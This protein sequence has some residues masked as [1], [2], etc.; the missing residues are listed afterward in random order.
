VR[1]DP[2]RMVITQGFTQALDLLCRVLADRGATTVAIE[3]PS[4]PELWSTVR[5]SGLRLLGCP[6]DADGLRTDALRDLV[7]DAVVVGPAHQYPT[8]VVMTAARRVELVRWAAMRGR[9]VI[10]DDYDAE[11]RYDRKPIG[12]IQGLD[13]SRVAHIGTASKTLVPAIRLGW[14]SL[15]ADLVAAVQAEKTIAD[16]GSPAIDQLAMGNLLSTGVYERQ[17]VRA[18]LEYQR[19][20]DLLVRA[21]SH[22]FSGFEVRGAAAGMQLLLRLP[23]GIDDV[24]IAVAAASNGIGI[25][26]LSPLHLVPSSDRG[27]LLGYGRLPEGRIDQAVG[28][29]RSVIGAARSWRD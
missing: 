26:A 27:L 25:R 20:R 19:R 13:P 12:A 28:A 16:S 6:V 3:S 18:R 1:V 5:R 10:E 14:A 24:A 8:G 29:L 21:L 7:A 4:H 11:F 23:R 2:G 9:L 22:Q 17:V 15:P